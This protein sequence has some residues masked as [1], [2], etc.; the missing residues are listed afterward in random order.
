M[1]CIADEEGS[2]I[3]AAPAKE[4]WGS[5]EADAA[6][7]TRHSIHL[8][9]EETEGRP[10]RREDRIRDPLTGNQIMNERLTG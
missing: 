1:G 7:R 2:D 5:N 8:R 6:G 9:V 3:E 4:A 10:S